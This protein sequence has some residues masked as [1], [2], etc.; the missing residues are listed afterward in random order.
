MGV[1][2]ERLKAVLA[3]HRQMRAWQAAYRKRHGLPA[4]ELPWE[5][6][7]KVQ[8]ILKI[9]MKLLVKMDW[10]IVRKLGRRNIGAVALFAAGVLALLN[11]QDMLTAVPFLAAHTKTIAMLGAWVFALGTAYKDDPK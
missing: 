6:S 9:L 2:K 11:Q 10:P 3:F 1:V 5:G 8:N 7:R 4:S